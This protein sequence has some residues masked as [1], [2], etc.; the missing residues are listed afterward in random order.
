MT[1]PS[2]HRRVP[3]RPGSPPSRSKRV[4][5]RSAR[6]PAITEAEAV[7]I[8]AAA[9]R[10][11]FEG[12]RCEFPGC[13]RLWRERHHVLKRRFWNAVDPAWA[14]ALV[15]LL[16]KE[17]H[18]WVESHGDAARA[19]GFTLKSWEARERGYLREKGNG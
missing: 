14:W 4:K 17:H 10:H 3:L 5:K 15:R 7:F 18:D 12:D 16:C 13:R 1:H 9:H 8:S 6:K 11:S 2:L 19:M